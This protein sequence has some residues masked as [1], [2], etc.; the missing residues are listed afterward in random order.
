PV[1]IGAVSAL[2]IFKDAV[3]GETRSHASLLAISGVRSFC[4][5]RC[6]EILQRETPRRHPDQMTIGS[7]AEIG[8][9]KRL[10]ISDMSST[11]IMADEAQSITLLLLDRAKQDRKIEVSYSGDDTE[12]EEKE[13]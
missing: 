7:S 11:H 10:T 1:L 13:R 3:V 12:M 9:A 6:Q 8:V 4:S 2:G 5:K